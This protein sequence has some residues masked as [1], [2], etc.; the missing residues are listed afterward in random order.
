MSSRKQAILPLK[1]VLTC[2]HGG[3]I[4]PEKYGAYFKNQPEILNTHRG[5]DLG[6]LDLFEYL[7]PLSYFSLSS[8]TSRLLIELNR[9]LHHKNLFSEF[10]LKLSKEEKKHLIQSYYLK[11]RDTV[12]NKIREL[13]QGE[14]T[15][16]HIS[17]HSFTPVLN[18]HIRN[19]DIGL[20]FDPKRNFEK[21]FSKN[22]KEN[23]LKINPEYHVRFN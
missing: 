16:L 20:L 22:F 11:Y 9:S 15:V 14:E 5:F 18:D 7:K 19:C 8:A 23:I 3:N 13:I 10:S 12:E 2:E 4:I 1:L 6:A 17:I 21:Q